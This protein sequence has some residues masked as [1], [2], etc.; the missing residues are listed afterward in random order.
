M[1]L[2]RPKI[3]W[4]HDQAPEPNEKV[5]FL[6]KYGILTMGNVTKHEWDSGF[7]VCWHRCPSKP[8]NWNEILEKKDGS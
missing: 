2:E 8:E 6:S 4:I 7:C 3:D 5:I 1:A